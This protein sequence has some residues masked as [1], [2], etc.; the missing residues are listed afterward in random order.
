MS[1]LPPLTPLP[2]PMGVPDPSAPPADLPDMVSRGKPS[3][4]QERAALLKEI[5]DD[6]R[7]ARA[8]WKPV[9]DRMIDDMNF[10]MGLQWPGSSLWKRHEDS[11]RYVVNICLRHVQQLTATLY[12]KNP[13][14]SAKLRP[15]I[16]NTVWDG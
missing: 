12:A 4:P 14:V 11:D 5:Q 10:T 8:H 9:F 13:R 1:D 7:R 2:D 3:P 16:L 6:V 15:R